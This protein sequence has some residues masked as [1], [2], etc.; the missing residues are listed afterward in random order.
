MAD[1]KRERNSAEGKARFVMS[2]V[3]ASDRMREEFAPIWEE[4]LANYLVQPKGAAGLGGGSWQ[5]MVQYPHYTG[6]ASGNTTSG[7]IL[8]DPEGHQ[9]VETLLSETWARVFGVPDFIK[10]RRVGIEDVAAGETVSRL[11]RYVLRREGHTLAFHG[12]GKDALTFGTGILEGGWQYVEMMRRMRQLD[13]STG[14]EIRRE[15]S[16]VFPVED[17]VRFSGVDLMDFYPEPGR[18]RIG[19]MHGVAKRFTMTARE[20]RK[21]IGSPGWDSAA[22]ER[23]ITANIS[24]DSHSEKD[25]WREG[26]DRPQNNQI[27]VEFKPLVGYEYWGELPPE[28]QIGQ[29]ERG[30][31]TVL[32]GELVSAREW[33]FYCPRLPFFEFTVNPIQG[34]FYGLSPLEV[35][36]FT[37][38]FTDSILMNIADGVSRSTYMSPI[39][40]RNANVDLAKLRARRP[41]M[42][43]MTDDSTPAGITYLPYAPPIGPAMNFFLSM[44]QHMREASGALGATQGLGLGIDRA[45]ATEAQATFQKA[46]GRPEMLAELV[47]R[48]YL[49]P[50]GKFAL[51]MYQQFLEDTPDL[52]RRVG[53]LP[54]NVDLSSILPEFD[55]EFLGSRMEHNKNSYV[56]ALERFVQVWALTPA[57]S[58]LPWDLLQKIHARKLDLYEVEAAIADPERVKMNLLMASL[59]G[60]NAAA[61]NGNGEQAALMDPSLSDAQA[62]GGIVQ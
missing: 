47:E 42:P 41:D 20:A 26:Y 8:K 36:R 48:E 6:R 30:V 59:S 45:S 29:D 16:G 52:A 39:V 62:G 5:S 22:V 9:I 33:P 31:L 18:F 55:L 56:E 10:C 40:N 51:E 12:W 44:K 19:D 23:A 37:Q 13:V 53:E 32:C 46:A 28:M 57:A 2:F 14:I 24:K 49:P 43:V 34:R 25:K 11:L 50:I 61:G 38:D 54:E 15:V 17:D 3:A 27:P 7:A 21:K 60:P 58:L 4:S 35:N 1:D